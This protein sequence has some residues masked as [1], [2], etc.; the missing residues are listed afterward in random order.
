MSRER[1]SEEFGR[2]IKR[3]KSMKYEQKE[4]GRREERRQD[5]LRKLACGLSSHFMHFCVTL[6]RNVRR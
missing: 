2:E 6:A 3:K 1:E 4:H 5:S